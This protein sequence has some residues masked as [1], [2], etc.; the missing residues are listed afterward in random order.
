[1]SSEAE[2]PAGVAPLEEP[3]DAGPVGIVYDIQ[4]FSVQDGPGIR[5][6]VFL[7]G[8]PLR[9]PWCH[10]PESQRF[11]IQLSWRYRKCVGTE[12]C[13]LCLSCCPQGAISLGEIGEPVSTGA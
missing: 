5:T 1:M 12:L 9:C 7:K 4:G 10:S 2:R 13:G 6:T 8:C 3:S 11:D